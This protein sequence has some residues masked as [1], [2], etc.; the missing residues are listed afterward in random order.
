M[1][2]IKS[3]DEQFYGRSGISRGIPFVTVYE[4]GGSRVLRVGGGHYE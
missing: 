3:T 4:S 2:I 1:A